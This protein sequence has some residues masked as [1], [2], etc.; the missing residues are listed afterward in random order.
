MPPRPIRP[1]VYAAALALSVLP[2]LSGPAAHAAEGEWSAAPVSAGGGRPYFY[3]EGAPGSVLEDRL[4][5]TNPT[6]R[7]LTLR[8]R[9]T[10]AT[11]TGTGTGAWIT[12]AAAE[13][14]IPPRTRAEVPF[15][16]TVP[17][18]APP[19]GHTAALVASGGGRQ[20]R[21]PVRVRVAGPVL[22]ALTVED[23]TLD[24][25]NSLIR[26]ALVNRGNTTLAPSLAVRA[27]GLWGRRLRR[28]ARPL[29]VALPPGGRAEL[30]EPWHPP[31]LDRVEVRLTVTAPGAARGEATATAAF[32][33][34]GPVAGAGC[35]AAGAGA[36]LWIRRRR[37][38]GADAP[39]EA[40]P[41]N[42]LATTG[43]AS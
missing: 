13:V 10:A 7:P 3:L 19:G 14:R 17:V 21:V 34:W 24:R 41:A 37:R 39:Q 43:A 20:A 30:T 8:L 29:P 33:P 9:G 40:R 36:A 38:Q 27:D 42:E 32:V 26:Y 11:G 15:T 2:A 4:S 28:P 1:A 25:G 5:L 35:A 16:V 18:G 6:G 22:A 12:P 31:A 23:V